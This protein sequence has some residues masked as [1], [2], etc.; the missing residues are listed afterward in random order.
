MA[1][2]D[3]EMAAIVHRHLREKGL[4]LRLRDGVKAFEKQDNRILVR[5]ASGDT[6]LTDMVLLSVGIRPDTKLAQDAGI[7]TIPAGKPGAGAILV[8]EHFHTNLPYIRAI[9]DA[10]AFKNPITGLKAGDLS[11]HWAMRISIPIISSK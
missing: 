2:L 9:G 10:V 3:F 6:M 11:I 4:E 7:A 8:D 1:P 5:L